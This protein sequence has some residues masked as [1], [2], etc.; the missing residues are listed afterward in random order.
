MI[1]S[2][3]GIEPRKTNKRQQ[4]TSIFAGICPRTHYE[5][6]FTAAQFHSTCY[7]RYLNPVEPFPTYCEVLVC[8]KWETGQPGYLPQNGT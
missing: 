5:Y 4:I 2:I 8:R 6:A 3:E 7:R 1:V